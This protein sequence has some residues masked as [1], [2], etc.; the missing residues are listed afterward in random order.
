MSKK[1]EKLP[2]VIIPLPNADKGFQEKWNKKRNIANFPH[3]FR[4]AII[5][6]QN[7]GKTTL[8]KNI[9]MRA[10][11]V[12]ERVIIIHCDAGSTKEYD[13]IDYV[14]YHDNIPEP[15][16]FDTENEKTLVIIEDVY[17]KELNKEQ[18]KNIDRLFGYVSSHKSVS[19]M[20]TSQIFV[21]LSPT[22][23]RMCNIIILGRIKDKIELSTVANKV[24]IRKELFM[25]LMEN[26]ITEQHDSL[27]IDMTSGSPYPLRKNLFEVLEES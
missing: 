15:S 22:I 2:D 11:P 4:I 12:F 13:D 6:K 16:E 9:L 18:R 17:V 10:D 5:G 7:M 25:N 27:C 1:S 26:E 21:S 23:R 3:S 20:V 19:I 14:E 8:I 24:G